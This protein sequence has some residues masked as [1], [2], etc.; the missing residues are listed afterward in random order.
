[1]YIYTYIYI[2]SIHIT[3]QWLSSL[4]PCGIPVSPYPPPVNPNPLLQRSQPRQSQLILSHFHRRQ[5]PATMIFPAIVWDTQWFGVA[6]RV[7]KRPKKNFTIL[8]SSQ[9]QGSVENP[10]NWTFPNALF[11]KGLTPEFHFT[12]AVALFKSTNG[13]FTT[14]WW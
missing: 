9:P 2:Y 12:R 3:S 7:V 10:F 11:S 6:T 14:A 8:K 5:L 13:T 1:M 4:R